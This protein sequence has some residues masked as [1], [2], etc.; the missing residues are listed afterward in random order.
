MAIVT[1]T[2]SAAALFKEQLAH[3]GNPCA[4]L[5]LVVFGGGGSGLRYPSK[6]GEHTSERDR[7]S[8]RFGVRVAPLDAR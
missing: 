3:D 4:A 8:R 7:E 5:R 2:K 1:P 6:F